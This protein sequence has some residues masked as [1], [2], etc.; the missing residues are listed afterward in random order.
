MSSCLSI[1]LIYN[2]FMKTILL[3]LMMMCFA[4][5]QAKTNDADSVLTFQLPMNCVGYNVL[6]DN[7]HVLF[8]VNPNSDNSLTKGDGDKTSVS[9]PGMISC[10]DCA[11][12]KTEWEKKIDFNYTLVKA[13]SQGI[14]ASHRNDNQQLTS[15]MLDFITGDVKYE[16]PV[17]VAYVN[18][19]HD[20]I[21]GYSRHLSDLLEA[22]RLSTG[23]PLWTA[24]VKCNPEE[25]FVDAKFIDKS[26]LVFGAKDL[27]M[28]DINNGSV[29]TYPCNTITE[30]NVRFQKEAQGKENFAFMFGVIGGA[31]ANAN[32]EKNIS[33][34]IK[35]VNP[36]YNRTSRAIN[37]L[38]SN[39]LSIGNK[40]YAADKRGLV[41]LNDDFTKVWSAKQKKLGKSKLVQFGDTLLLQ[42]LGY[43]IAGKDYTSIS[44]VSIT[45]YN[46][47]TGEIL[48]RD[49][50]KNFTND[51]YVGLD[52]VVFDSLYIYNDFE[53]S[54]SY[55]P[56]YATTL[57]YFD[58]KGNLKIVTPKG[59][60]I[61]TYPKEKVFRK[62]N[63]FGDVT[64]MYG[65][66]HHLYHLVDSDKHVLKTYE[67][68][69]VFM[70]IIN[71]VLIARD[72][73]YKMYVINIQK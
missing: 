17:G 15:K 3:S 7:R 46:I 60:I 19:D 73:D 16:I 41:C 67:E 28:L 62:G 69:Y 57:R 5:L 9:E 42:N 35:M 20:I 37:G 65:A 40:I 55:L 39:I 64:L 54:F 36:L 52:D 1:I 44:A 53:K 70:G 14:I 71:G 29:V 59:T 8:Q 11:T 58:T 31:I 50:F 38:R 13:T 72:K 18:E 43:G 22:Y 51:D 24:E 61:A 56:Q 49:M 23:E 32:Y 6:V 48:D 63:S 45:A 47:H 66:K 34:R 33:K 27:C 4:S 21:L 25:F 26:H 30:D 10:Y 12:D 2:L 68:P